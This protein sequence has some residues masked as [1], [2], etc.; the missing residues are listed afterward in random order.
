MDP[1]AAEN[2]RDLSQECI[3]ALPG[4]FARI[5]GGSSASVS[6]RGAAAGKELHVMLLA[7]H[8]GPRALHETLRLGIVDSCA[9]QPTLD[10]AEYILK[11]T[12]AHG[13]TTVTQ[14]LAFSC[15]RTACHIANFEHWGSHNHSAARHLYFDSMY[16]AIPKLGDHVGALM[17]GT[18][19]MNPWKSLTEVRS[20]MSEIFRRLT[21]IA[22]SSCSIERAGASWLQVFLLLAF[23]K[24][25][26]LCV[27]A[28]KSAVEAGIMDVLIK[29]LASDDLQS[30][31][32][33]AHTNAGLYMLQYALY[34]EDSAHGMF[35]TTMVAAVTRCIHRTQS[36]GASAHVCLNKNLGQI[37]ACMASTKLNVGQLVAAPGL[38]D[39]LQWLLQNGG[40][41]IGHVSKVDPLAAAGLALALIS[42]RN[43]DELLT[44]P[45]KI[46]RLMVTELDVYMNLGPAKA[47]PWAQGLAELCISDRHKEYLVEFPEVIDCLCRALSLSEDDTESDTLV[48][49]YTQK[50]RGLSCMT[51]A[52][53]AVSPRTRPMFK[54]H[55]VISKLE[56][57]HATINFVQRLRPNKDLV[58]LR[59]NIET[60]LASVHS[61]IIASV[62]PQLK[63]DRSDD[64]AASAHVMLSYEW[65][66]QGTIIQLNASLRERGYRTWLDID[67]MAGSTIDSMSDAIDRAAA[68]LYTVCQ[69]Y[70]ES[71]NCRL[72][73]N[74][75]H[76][77]QIEM[78]PL[79]MEAGYKPRGWLGM[80][81]GTRLW[82][83]FYGAVLDDAVCRRP[84]RP[85]HPPSLPPSAFTKCTPPLLI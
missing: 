20:R 37:V 46:V 40:D 28:A 72:E 32:M 45:P 57:L 34:D 74:Y 10:T 1:G 78:I 31:E 16:E 63:K 77:A 59:L 26:D 61:G 67:E 30:A 24:K 48:D 8:G 4:F 58:E 75:G 47:L 68:M 84:T 22:R 80:L 42:R 23:G 65:S 33:Y 7:A 52:Q 54:G 51:L 55:S 60:V 11:G 17:E 21:S 25:P 64:H 36:A 5:Q 76:A 81:M 35:T 12:C 14:L 49:D 39:A 71:S 85:T 13:C 9:T 79:K 43:D 41:P 29:A 19:V 56:M 82:Y 62:V 44:L 53:L 83:G 15:A 27:M 18:F 3:D 38:I 66:V 50:L 2:D 6:E 73:A 70:K 69:A